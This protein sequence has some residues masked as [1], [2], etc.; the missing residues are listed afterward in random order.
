MEEIYWYEFDYDLGNTNLYITNELDDDL[1]DVYIKENYVRIYFKNDFKD[2]KEIIEFV[3][4][5]G[6]EKH[7][8]CFYIYI[9]TFTF[10]EQYKFMLLFMDAFKEY[11]DETLKKYNR[12]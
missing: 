1:L 3:E 9:K 7:G 5:Y 11:F 8:N 2:N 6:F 4:E 10:E 12:G